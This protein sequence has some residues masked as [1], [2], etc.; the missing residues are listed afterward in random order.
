MISSRTIAALIAALAC[1]GGAF[2]QAYIGVGAG[3][4]NLD[5]DCTGTIS[6]NNSSTGAKIFAGY[7]INQSIAVE[8][9]YIDFG[10]AKASAASNVG[11]V[12]IENKN[13]LVGGGIALHGDISPSW[14]AVARL[15]IGSMSVDITGV[16][17][18]Q[19][20]PLSESSTQ[21]YFGLGVGYAVT[22][23]LSLNGAIDFSQAKFSGESA[24]VRLFSVG[25]TYAF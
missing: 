16:V 8:F 15:G 20:V 1:S 13:S 4:A 18:G 2:A 3:S 25:L 7:K 22:K 14:N 12:N 19:S 5:A 9:N 6:C 11:I 23:Q 21:A 24:N 10:T 17:N